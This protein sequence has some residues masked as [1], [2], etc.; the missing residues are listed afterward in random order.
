MHCFLGPQ[1]VLGPLDVLAARDTLQSAMIENVVRIC[2]LALGRH[3]GT[4]PLPSRAGRLRPR[5][6]EAAHLAGSGRLP[7]IRRLFGN[8]CTTT[9]MRHNKSALIAKMAEADAYAQRKVKLNTPAA[10]TRSS[11]GCYE[12][13]TDNRLLVN[14]MQQLLLVL[15]HLP[16]GMHPPRVRMASGGPTA[17]L[18]A[19]LREYKMRSME[20]D[21]W[22]C[23]LGCVIAQ[24]L[25]ASKTDSMCVSNAFVNPRAGASLRCFCFSQ[26]VFSFC[27]FPADVGGRTHSSTTH[28]Q[29]AREAVRLVTMLDGEKHPSKRLFC[30]RR[31][32]SAFE[33]CV[34]PIRTRQPQRLSVR[35]ENPEQANSKSRSID[36]RTLLPSYH[37]VCFDGGRTGEGVRRRSSGRRPGLSKSQLVI[38]CSQDGMEGIRVPG[39]MGIGC[40]VC[41][42]WL[43]ELC[44]LSTVPSAILTQLED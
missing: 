41:Y 3:R 32:L 5:S 28:S 29:R 4:P 38:L 8:I 30:Q 7:L 36:A 27:P 42:L 25:F 2:S 17:G 35:G 31:W 22:N 13:V 1:A 23:F 40:S 24:C 12:D 34:S 18:S 33:L 6:L 9:R 16:V 14:S 20:A 44:E 37:R 26:F 10:V 11:G 21:A 15:R 43:C 19:D 39:G